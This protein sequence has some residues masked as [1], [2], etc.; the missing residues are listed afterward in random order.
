MSPAGDRGAAGMEPFQG[1]PAAPVAPAWIIPVDEMPVTLE[2]IVQ[3][4]G[5]EDADGFVLAVL[6]RDHGDEVIADGPPAAVAACL[7]ELAAAIRAGM[8]DLQ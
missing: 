5:M 2:Q 1:S 8:A 6:R 4:T 3:L 7:S